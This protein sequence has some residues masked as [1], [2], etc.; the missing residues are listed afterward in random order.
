[1]KTKWRFV[2]DTD[3][4]AG[5]FEREMCAYVTGVVGDCTTGEDFA[6][7]YL[8]ETKEEESQ[9]LDYIE[10]RPDEH[11]N[12]RPTS[13]YKTKGP[14]KEPYNSVAIFFNKRPSDSMISLMKSRVEKF[15]EAKR[16][17]T[18]YN[19][20]FQLTIHKFRLIRVTTSEEDVEI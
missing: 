1:M 6:A 15:A 11:G 12:F 9:F 8:Q 20:N 16:N 10:Q 19:K 13:I 7:I 17:I 3:S 18:P 5:N 4:Y 2:I 14:K